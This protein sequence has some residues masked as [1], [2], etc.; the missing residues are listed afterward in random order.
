MKFRA[1]FDV[2]ADLVLDKGRAPLAVQGDDCTI[3][4]SNAPVDK[5]GFAPSLLA[6]VVA[7]AA[8][9][10]TAGDELRAMLARHLDILAFATHSRFKIYQVRRVIEWEPR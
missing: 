10:D 5:D 8:S 7:E 9:F 6:A 1:D 3:T 2:T 4:F